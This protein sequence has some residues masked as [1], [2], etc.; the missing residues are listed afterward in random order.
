MRL[1]TAINFNDATRSRLVSIRDEIKSKSARGNFTAPQNIHLTLI[2]LGESDERQFAAAKSALDSTKF[3]PFDIEIYTTG[4]FAR[5][6]GDIWWAGVRECA[7]LTDLYKD[8]FDKLTGAGFRVDARRY[9]PHITLSREVVINKRPYTN[10]EQARKL[11]PAETVVSKFE[12]FGEK[13]YSVD[14]MKSERLH[15]N[16]VYTKIYS[17]LAD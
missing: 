1:F 14:L 3:A 16:L 8:L 7:P 15:G 17:T 12:P 11:P 2:F 4:R 6:G 5:D 13:V 9:K 10:S